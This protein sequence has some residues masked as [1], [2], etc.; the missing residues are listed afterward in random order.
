M[1]TFPIKK[2]NNL[3]NLRHTFALHPVGDGETDDSLEGSAESVVTVVA[4]PFC[5][6]ECGNRT[7]FLSCFTIEMDEVVDVQAEGAKVFKNNVSTA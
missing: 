2:C 5:Q 4:T 7:V 1:S 6:S 3:Y